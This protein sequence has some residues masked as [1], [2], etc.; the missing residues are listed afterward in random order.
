MLNIIFEDKNLIVLI[1]PVG[2]SSEDGM[3][4]L[5]REHLEDG[6][7]YVGIIHRLD[8]AVSGIMVYAKTKAAAAHLSRQIIAG[9]FKKEYLAVVSGEPEHI[10]GRYDDLL[11]K[12]S[13]KNKSYVVKRERRGVKKAALEY[14]TVGST[15]FDGGKVTL[16]KIRLLTGRTHQIRVQFSS[17]KM[18]LLGD[19]KY[20]SRYDG[21]I[22]LYSHSLTFMCPETEKELRFISNP[23]NTFPFNRFPK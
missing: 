2:V 23:E 11:F 4:T 9:T 19:K 8:T 21:P 12:D 5:I 10:S 16:V 3:V 15:V 17:R 6:R 18:P 13:K 22:A 7:A 14:E 1:K 20:G